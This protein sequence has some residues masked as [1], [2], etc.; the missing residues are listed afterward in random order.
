MSPHTSRTL[1]FVTLVFNLVHLSNEP[2]PTRWL[3]LL[4]SLYAHSYPHFPRSFSF[5]LTALGRY[6]PEL[7][8]VDESMSIWTFVLASASK[9]TNPHFDPDRFKSCIWPSSSAQKFQVWEA[10]WLRWD[11]EMHPRDDLAGIWVY[12]GA[13]DWF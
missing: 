13:P 2:F 6:D 1:P 7:Q 12:D 4:A 8:L 9:F 11:P 10:Y 3:A 5:P